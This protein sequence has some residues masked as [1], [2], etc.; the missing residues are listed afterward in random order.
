[1]PNLSRNHGVSYTVVRN[2]TNR[3]FFAPWFPAHNG[4]G[5]TLA[6]NTTVKFKG[7]LFEAMLGY[8][9]FT[10][11]LLADVKSGAVAITVCGDDVLTYAPVQQQAITPG[12]WSC[13]D[14]EYDS[15]SSAWVGS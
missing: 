12:D 11:Q 8:P 4:F 13:L 9:G 7:N 2:L 15:S 5:V 3:E 6:A 14:W 10:A 1:M